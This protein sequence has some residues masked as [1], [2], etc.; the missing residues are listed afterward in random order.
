MHMRKINRIGIVGAGD[1]GSSVAAELRSNGFDVTTCLEGRSTRSRK[2]ATRAGMRA[3]DNLETLVADAD[4][5]LSII[6][7]SAAAEFARRI[8]PLVEQTASKPL[9]V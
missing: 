9:F 7:P 5:L 3:V 4:L 1:M 2:L 6:P 8:V